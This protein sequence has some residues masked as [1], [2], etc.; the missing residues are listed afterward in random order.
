MK[1]EP[2]RPA[3][4]VEPATS[5]DALAFVRELQKRGAKRTPQDAARVADFLN[6]MPLGQLK[7]IARRIMM[8]IMKGPPGGSDA[9]RPAPPKRGPSG[10]QP[11]KKARSAAKKARPAAKKARPRG[12]T[13]R[14]KR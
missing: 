11:K 2:P 7:G 4:L 10:Q 5:A 9:A 6:S 1:R 13:R 8:D 14:G 12:K 3:P